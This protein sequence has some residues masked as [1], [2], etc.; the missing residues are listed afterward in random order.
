MPAPD[1]LKELQRCLRY[2]QAAAWEK[3]WID[4]RRF[5]TNQLLKF[6][7]IGGGIGSIR[8]ADA[9]HLPGFVIVIGE[10][11]S[12][13]IASYGFVE[14]KLTEALLRLVQP[15]QVVVDIGMHLGY[16]ATLLALL[17]G[18]QGEVHGFEPTPSTRRIAEKNT[19][20]FPQIRV[21]PFAA[22]SSVKTLMFRDYGPQW[23]AFNSFSKAKLGT[24]PVTPKEIEVQTTTLD[25]F[26]A[27]MNRSI[28]LVKIDA[29]S[30]EREILAGAKELLRTD[31]P[32]ITVEVGDNDESKTSRALVDDLIA[33]DYR[34]WEFDERQFHPHEPRERYAYDNLIFAPS[35]QDISSIRG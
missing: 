2:Q 10:G 33:L 25:Q 22:W 3:P 7:L 4:S 6:G 27:P 31:R 16:Y 19:S 24:E 28:A 9:F 20:R 8:A 13:E 12:Q 34:P 14:P 30:A 15:G 11:V 1:L 18:E 23:M 26:R 21:H 5:V 32:I 17:V 29:E 35:G